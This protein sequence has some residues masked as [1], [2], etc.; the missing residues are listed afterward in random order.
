MITDA[1]YRAAFGTYVNLCLTSELFLLS[2]DSPAPLPMAGDLKTSGFRLL[3][4]YPIFHCSLYFLRS[5]FVMK[6]DLQMTLW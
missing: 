1:I 5:F 4:F 3:Y 2:F 6:Y